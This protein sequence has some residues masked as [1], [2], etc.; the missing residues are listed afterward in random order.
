MVADADMHLELSSTE[1]LL[2]EGAARQHAPLP[3]LQGGWKQEL[4]LKAKRLLPAKR[5]HLGEQ[6]RH[7]APW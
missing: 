7:P 5:V 2:V 6:Q 1:Q 4:R 3:D